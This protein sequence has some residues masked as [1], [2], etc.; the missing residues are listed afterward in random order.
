M[1]GAPDRKGRSGAFAGLVA[2]LALAVVPA[3]VWV[4]DAASSAP[5][6]QPPAVTA[7]PAPV[8]AQAVAAPASASTAAEPGPPV[9]IRLPALGV[10]A[11]VAPVGVDDRGRMEVPLS[12]ATVGWYR[13]G[14]GP[15]AAA[16]SAVL[17]GHV[18]DR[19][20]GYGAFHRLGDL[21]PGDPVTVD[22][23]DGA[24]VTY[25]VETV[26][27]VPKADLPVGDVFSRDGAPRLTLVT[28]GGAFDYDAQG[29]T[30]NV[31]VVA[32]PEG[33]GGRQR[34]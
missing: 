20:Q 8:P 2:G 12:V 25:R 29:Y 15:G 14:P 32:R 16:G 17:S 34:E 31:V 30:D 10:D 5:A 21:A 33:L 24:T 7:P 3:G 11:A 9:R 19:D 26:T 28:C 22:L 13:F 18:D 4:A 23:A 27:R 1:S 6:P